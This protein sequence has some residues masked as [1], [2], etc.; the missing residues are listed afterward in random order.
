MILLLVGGYYFVKKITRPIKNLTLIAQKVTSVNSKSKLKE[1]PINHDEIDN[2][3]NLFKNMIR[4]LSKNTVSKDYL[5]IILQRIDE[6]LIIT[7]L[8]GDILIVNKSTLEL[9]KY[10]EQELIGESI[11]KVL[12]GE[13]K[14]IP[15]T[16]E[17]ESAQNIFNTYFTKDNE[18]IPITFSKS[19][20]Y[21]SN[22]HKT[23]ILY[24]AYNQRERDDDKEVL[25][26]DALLDKGKIKIKEKTPLTNREIDILKL[27]VKDYSN[28]EIADKLFISIRTVE[29]H[30]K[31]IMVKLHVKS[32]IGLVHYAIQ[33]NLI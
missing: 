16:T 15:T 22:N 32:T 31:N 24:L 26:D 33:N 13:R 17:D 12:L 28:Q 29:T 1:L 27:I 10:A 7:N 3:S 6:S 23:G 5:N 19:F 8:D 30:R 11:N 25:K 21:D 9:L 14:N 20:I 2:F 4:V 18:A